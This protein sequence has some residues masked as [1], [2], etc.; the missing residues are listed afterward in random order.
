MT[1]PT[2]EFLAE[3]DRIFRSDNPPPANPDLVE[4]RLGPARV[5]MSTEEHQSALTVGKQ[6][7]G[8]QRLNAAVIAQQ[9]KAKEAT[10]AG[11]SPLPPEELTMGNTMDVAVNRPPL[12]PIQTAPSTPEPAKKRG[13]IFSRFRARPGET[14]KIQ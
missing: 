7:T 12:D 6:Q 8:E 10:R 3:R 1:E 2:P 13:G 4:E 5:D 9:V 11:V 14:G